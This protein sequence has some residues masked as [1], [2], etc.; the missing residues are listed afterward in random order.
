MKEEQLYKIAIE[1]NL[2]PEGRVYRNIIKKRRHAQG[3]RRTAMAIAA[4]IVVAVIAVACIPAARAAVLE[5][6]RPAVEPDIYLNTPVEERTAAPELDAAI[7]PVNGQAVTISVS[8]AVDDEWRAWAERLSVELDEILYDGQSVYLTGSLTGNTADLAK[9]FDEYIKTQSAAATT[10]SPPDDMV[11]CRALYSVNGGEFNDTGLSALNSGHEDAQAN[12]AKGS[13]PL[14][15]ALD[16]GEGL[17]GRQELCVE[18]VF[19]DMGSLRKA[20]SPAEMKSIIMA[21]LRIDGLQFDATAGTDMNNMLPTPEAVKLSGDA[22]IFSIDEDEANST[23]AVGNDRLS[24]EGGEFGVIKLRQQL[25]GTSMAFLI[26]LPDSWTEEQCAMVSDKLS[27]NFIIN[28]EDRGGFGD[29]YTGIRNYD[30]NS[31][32]QLALSDPPDVSDKHNIVFT[33]D[34]GFMPDDWES[35]SSFEALLLIYELTEYNGITLP[36]GSRTQVKTEPGGWNEHGAVRRLE[37]CILK[38]K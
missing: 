2:A 24:L 18:L 28:G 5:W 17:T 34:T 25:T 9:P 6:L 7:E 13:L 29:A 11:V 14:S 38:I 12:I 20:T 35:M 26:K 4:C 36:A 37:D 19:A 22:L 8:Q 3:V 33:V 30:A 23:A 16:V 15:I 21:T 10:A 1:R 27:V 31:I 32:A